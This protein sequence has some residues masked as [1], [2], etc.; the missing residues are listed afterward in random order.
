MK[1]HTKIYTDFFGYG[2]QSFMP[3]EVC[4]SLGVDVHHIVPRGMG[5]SKGKD[6]IENL[7]G[8][9]RYHHDCAEGIRE[10]KLSNEYLT[11]KH[12][13]FIENFKKENQGGRK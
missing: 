7:I 9:C 10:P 1:K 5:G 13:E 8:L 2:E 12:A 4:G 6:T 3:C 11:Q